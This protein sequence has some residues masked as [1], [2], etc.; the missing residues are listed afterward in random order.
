MAAGVES[1]NPITEYGND[2]DNPEY[3][4]MKCQ[5]NSRASVLALNYVALIRLVTI[6]SYF[7]SDLPGGGLFTS[8]IIRLDRPAHPLRPARHL[9]PALM[10]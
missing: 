6:P 9:L 4:N 5:T 2:P 1:E 7:H 10:P 8:R 3:P